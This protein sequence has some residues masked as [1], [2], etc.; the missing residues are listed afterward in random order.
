[1]DRNH[2]ILNLML[3][4]LKSSRLLSEMFIVFAAHALRYSYEANMKF[5]QSCLGHQLSDVERFNTYTSLVHQIL[6]Q[7]LP[8]PQPYTCISL[9]RYGSIYSDHLY[10]LPHDSAKSNLSNYLFE[11]KMRAVFVINREPLFVPNLTC[12]VHFTGHT[13]W[14]W[15]WHEIRLNLYHSALKKLMLATEPMQ[16]DQVSN[17]DDEEMLFSRGAKF[18]LFLNYR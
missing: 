2:S 10:W 1:M 14:I 18:R 5:D 3:T 4:R 12:N 8:Q 16:H 15:I 11:F 6:N 7:I 17:G 13:K 9:G